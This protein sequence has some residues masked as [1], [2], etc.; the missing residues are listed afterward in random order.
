MRERIHSAKFRITIVNTG[1][2]NSHETVPCA[3]IPSR[4]K[5][6]ETPP[7]PARSSDHA[8]ATPLRPQALLVSVRSGGAVNTPPAAMHS[9]AKTSSDEDINTPFMVVW[10][11][12]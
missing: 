2:L 7:R 12:T 3:R 4:D 5:P 1:M 6:T 11:A 10:P 8:L 9:Q